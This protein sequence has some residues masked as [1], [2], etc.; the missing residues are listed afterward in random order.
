MDQSSD[1]IENEKFPILFLGTQMTLAGAQEVLLTQARWFHEQGYPVTATFFYD[2]EGLAP[3]WRSAHPFPV[4]SLN[5]WVYTSGKFRNAFRLVGGLWR[6]FQLLRK[7]NFTVIE[8][9]TPHSDILGIPVAWA[10]GV[11]VRLATH[12]GYIENST[13]FLARIHG[14]LL[15][16]GIATFMVAVSRQVK[17]F[18]IQKENTDPARV[19]VILN[20]IEF[21]KVPGDPQQ[22]REEV[23]KELQVP[24]E[25]VLAINVA[26]FTRQKGHTYLLDAIPEILNE[27]PNTIFAFAGE[28]P[29][30][31]EIEEKARSLGINDFIRFLGNRKDIPRLLN[32][33]DIFVMPSLW[34]GLPMALLEAMAVGL[35]VV[36]TAVEGVKDMIETNVN[37]I[38]IPIQD[39][40]AL[41]EKM[42]VLIA[43]PSDRQRLGK[44]GQELVV[45]KFNNDRMCR[46]YEALFHKLAVSR[47]YRLSEQ[48][49]D[50]YS[51]E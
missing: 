20:G 27:N 45:S 32:A 29:Y 24:A 9:F 48:P 33:A 18:A 49:E 6:L 25:S 37:G 17:E 12:H 14:W 39:V 5:S 34:E 19:Q 51:R 1:P 21:P 38:M 15:N 22:A 41:I 36:V 28:G 47:H 10:A 31:N 4:I 2:K 50:I 30:K 23:R 40:P 42:N 35:P 26:R 7:N 44:A 8:T 16:S 3:S 13:Q 43:S 46:E 11:P